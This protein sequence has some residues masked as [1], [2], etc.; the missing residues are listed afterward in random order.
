MQN[1]TSINELISRIK[2]MHHQGYDKDS[3]PGR[4]IEM[5]FDKET[6]DVC[7]QQYIKMKDKQHRQA[8]LMLILTGALTLVFSCVLTI[9][10]HYNNQSLEFVMY[11]VTSVGLII[12]FAGLMK[13]F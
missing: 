12:V 2:D 11:G 7:F 5:G 13:I 10:L 8:G 6:V 4:L 1:E 9:V 3:I